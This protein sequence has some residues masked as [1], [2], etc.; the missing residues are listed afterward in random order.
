M[1]LRQIWDKLVREGEP[2]IEFEEFEELLNDWAWEEL[3]RQREGVTGNIYK[4][5]RD[6]PI[7]GF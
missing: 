7:D 5:E 6:L 4:P 2:G 1:M 3:A